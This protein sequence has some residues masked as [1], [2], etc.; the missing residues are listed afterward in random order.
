[1]RGDR[2]G[3]GGDLSRILDPQVLDPLLEALRRRGFTP[4][5]PTVRQGAICYDEIESAADL[6]AGWTDEQD[7]GSYR[8]RRSDNG[9]IFNHNVGPNSW[10]SHLFPASLKLWKAQRNGNGLQVEEEPAGQ[11][12]PYA[13]I[14]VRSCDMHAIAV[15]DKTFVEGPWADPDY[16]GRR[17]GA[18]IVT[19]NCGKAGGT[20]FCVS[21][22]TGPK[23]TF[24]FDLSLTELLDDDGHRFLVEV[25]SERGAEVLQEVDTRPSADGDER[26]A[27]RVIAETAAS[28]GRSLDTTDI[29]DLLYRNRE[30]PRWDEVADR[31][32]TCGNCT[33]ACPTCFCS[34][35]EDVTDLAGEEATR[36]RKWESCFTLE[37]TY[38]HGGSVR[39]SSKARYRQ[40][41]THKLASWIDQFG[42]SGCIGCGRCIT[43]CPVAIDITEEAAA[44]RAS[45]MEGSSGGENR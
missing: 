18:F 30:H 21:M 17:E 23:A 43:W 39:S 24:G 34:S 33:L 44:I 9:A 16:K 28:M 1:V 25:G 13:F 31:C 12:A 41:M 3:P 2:D 36:V 11:G 27:D 20:C 8:L 37:H 10:K 45:D 7:G 22:E 15:Q 26:A 38:V 32:L 19:V 29:R 40:W 35:V 4:I 5:G 14:G 42:T 6:P